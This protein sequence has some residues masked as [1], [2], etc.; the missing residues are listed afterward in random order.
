[1]TLLS[2]DD[3]KE[4]RKLFASLENTVQIKAYTQ[5]N[6]CDSC[7]DTKSILTELGGLSDKLDITFPDIDDNKED[8][9][10]DSIEMVPALLVSDGSHTRVR[11]YGTPAGYEFSTLLTVIIDSG[12]ASDNLSDETIDFLDST[13]SQDTPLEIKVFV[14]PTCPHCPGAAILASRL[15]GYSKNVHTEIIEGNEFPELSRK[16]QIM[17]VPKTV[18]NERF[19]AEGTLSE[20]MFIQALESALK[21][22]PQGKV[23]LMD[24]LNPEN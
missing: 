19:H 22:S 13:F 2:D 20:A 15:A 7:R 10:Q 23:N 3:T 8:A 17:G 16:Y 5:K 9:E 21:D 18:V 24:Y 12:T 1:M 14:T 4:V 6:N 11:F